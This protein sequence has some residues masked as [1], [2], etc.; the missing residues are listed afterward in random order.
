MTSANGSICP[1]R[2]LKYRRSASCTTSDFL[3]N[4]LRQT[5][6]KAYSISA[7]TVTE[8]ALYL[9]V[10]FMIIIPLLDMIQSYWIIVRRQGLP[11]YNVRYIVHVIPF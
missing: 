11:V 6:L 2:I 8:I 1:V 5:S 4:S 7:G 3:R 10:V 9:A